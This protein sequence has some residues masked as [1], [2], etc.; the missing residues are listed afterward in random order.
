MALVC[1]LKRFALFLR[2][3]LHKKRFRGPKYVKIITGS[4]K[5]REKIVRVVFP[6]AWH[7]RK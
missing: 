3:Q 1:D 6:R 5:L 7:P 4:I 2:Q